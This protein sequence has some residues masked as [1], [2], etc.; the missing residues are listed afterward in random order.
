[1]EIGKEQCMQKYQAL[2]PKSPLPQELL[3]TMLENAVHP[4]ESLRIVK[5]QA[6]QHKAHTGIDLTYP[7]YTSLLLSAAQQHDKQMLDPEKVQYPRRKVY[8]HEYGYGE[9]QSDNYYDNSNTKY[10]IDSTISLLSIN[11]AIQNYYNPHLSKQK[12]YNF[13]EKKKKNLEVIAQ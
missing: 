9:S 2:A 1:M 8:N 3:R 13:T 12:W 11:Q 4:I 7:Q 6:S 5:T 10:D